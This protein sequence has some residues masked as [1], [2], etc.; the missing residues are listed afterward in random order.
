TDPHNDKTA[1]AK[2]KAQY[3][4]PVDQYIG[5]VEHAVL[6]LL[7]SRFF[8]RAL[9]DCG[10]L[11]IAEPFAGL[12]TQGMVTHE[13]YQDGAGKWLYPT[14]ITK[15]DNGTITTADGKPVTVG[16]S[17]KM[18]KSKRNTVDPQDILD[19]YGADAARLFILSDSPPERDLEWS[20]AGIEG[21]WRF[22]NRLH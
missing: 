13:T 17:I 20:E 11:D 19:G 12:F 2:D 6:H 21:A 9:R 15:N 14:E 4:L 10:Y 5:G 18:S 16:P 22:I 8:T 7:Y 1:F 3:W